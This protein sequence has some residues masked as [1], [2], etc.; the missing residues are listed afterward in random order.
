MKSSLPL[1]LT[2]VTLAVALIHQMRE[3][4]AAKGKLAAALASTPGRL[5]PD[6]PPAAV[7]DDLFPVQGDLRHLVDCERREAPHF[8]Q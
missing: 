8:I 1:I 7:G 2:I 5:I 4:R 3:R 6:D